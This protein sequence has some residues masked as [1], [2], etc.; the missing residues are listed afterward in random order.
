M[1]PSFK[2]LSDGFRP[3]ESALLKKVPA[4]GAK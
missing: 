3:L 2:A 4:A 1:L